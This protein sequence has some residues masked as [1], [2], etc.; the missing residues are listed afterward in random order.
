M[1]AVMSAVLDENL[2]S[3]QLGLQPLTAVYS[4]IDRAAE[5]IFGR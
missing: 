5:L 3:W 4:A 2:G 1:T